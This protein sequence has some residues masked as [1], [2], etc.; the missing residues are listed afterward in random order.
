MIDD[1]PTPIRALG[2]VGQSCKPELYRISAIELPAQPI[3]GNLRQPMTTLDAFSGS[4][5]YK[6]NYDNEQVALRYMHKAQLEYLGHEDVNIF[7]QDT[8]PPS[9]STR[10]LQAWNLPILHW[11]TAYPV[12]R[13]RHPGT[14]LRLSTTKSAPLQSS[15]SSSKNDPVPHLASDSSRRSGTMGLSIH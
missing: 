12:A 11:L 3:L 4:A 7:T 10:S 14:I 9:I 15:A 8:H 13:T 6:L 5:R 1:L 2:L